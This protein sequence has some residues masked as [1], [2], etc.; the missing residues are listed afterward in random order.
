AH[1]HVLPSFP[2]R[3]SSDLG[4]LLTT[5]SKYA[6]DPLQLEHDLTERFVGRQN[7]PRGVRQL[8]ASIKRMSEGAKPSIESWEFQGYGVVLPRSEEHTSEL[9]SLRHLVC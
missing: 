6:G 4:S 5:R 3:R 1:P 7:R 2:T 9:Q 8:A